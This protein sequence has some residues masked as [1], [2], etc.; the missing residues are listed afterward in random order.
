MFFFPINFAVP[1]RELDY[2]S[3]GDSIEGLRNEL[4]SPLSLIEEGTLLK[5]TL[6][7]WI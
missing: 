1:E 6:T 7:S 4:S 2:K 5:R 3:R